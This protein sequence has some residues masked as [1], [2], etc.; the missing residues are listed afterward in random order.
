[1]DKFDTEKKCRNLH[2]DPLITSRYVFAKAIHAF[3]ALLASSAALHTFALEGMPLAGR[4]IETIATGL[5]GNKH[6]ALRQI[7]LARCAL[8]DEACRTLC[9]ALRTMP[10]LER[11]DL[12]GCGL[13]EPGASSVAE[14]LRVSIVQ[15][16][17][18]RTR[19]CI[20]YGFLQ[21]F[22]DSTRKSNAFRTRGRSRSAIG[23]SIPTKYP[24]LSTSVWPIIRP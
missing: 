9:A 4:Y 23:T 16:I 24:A 8:G 19:V 18:R 20:G 6:R 17:L 22:V 1:M 5:S 15:Q 7:T 2:T 13:G 11:V 3:G 10:S 14:L 12:S 21:N